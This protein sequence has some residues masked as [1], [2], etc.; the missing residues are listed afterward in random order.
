MHLY[1]PQGYLCQ[2]KETD[3]EKA[4]QPDRQTDRIP[5]VQT[6]KYTY[7]SCHEWL[8]V[9]SYVDPPSGGL[10]NKNH[11]FGKLVK[12]EKTE[13]QKNNNL[14]DGTSKGFKILHNYHFSLQMGGFIQT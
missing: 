10:L 13:R 7:F 4:S 6:Q 11:P 3:G 8:A 5:T 2:H 14:L 1:C 12:K 9:F